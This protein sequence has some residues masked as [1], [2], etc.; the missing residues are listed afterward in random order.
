[1]SASIDGIAT[2]S[3]VT[4]K[5]VSVAVEVQPRSAS[6]GAIGDSRVFTA[7]LFD[8]GS[9]PLTQPEVV[10]SSSNPTVATVAGTGSSGTVT[11]RA[12]GSTTIT[13]SSNGKPDAVL[14]VVAPQAEVLAILSTATTIQAGQTATLSAKLADA[15]GN[16]IRDAPATFTTT[17]PNVLSV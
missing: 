1:I 17:T 16:V 7:S 14:F 3:D 9:N 13:A 12:A 8:A 5:Q 4:I 15:N 10:W 11:A 6:V 2:R